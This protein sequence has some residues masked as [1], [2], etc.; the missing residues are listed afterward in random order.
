M[1]NFEF[2]VADHRLI[3]YVDLDM[4]PIQTEI[5]AENVEDAIQQFRKSVMAVADDYRSCEDF[6]NCPDNFF[7]NMTV[8]AGLIDA[9]DN[10]ERY[11]CC[12]MRTLHTVNIT[13][14]ADR[15]EVEILLYDKAE[16]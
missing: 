1:K 4:N 10:K 2:V 14:Y 7:Y 3:A 16:M 13:E 11:H 12:D 6:M 9:T 15:T 8:Y 5:E